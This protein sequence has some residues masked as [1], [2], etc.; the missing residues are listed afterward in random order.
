MKKLIS[1]VMVL[2]MIVCTLISFRALSEGDTGKSC[3][4]GTVLTKETEAFCLETFRDARSPEHL[5]KLVIR[6]ALER[7]TYDEGCATCPQTIDTNR[8][9]F[10]NTFHGVCADFAAFFNTVIQ[11]VSRHK[12][13][14]YVGCHTMLGMDLASGSG[15]AVNYLSVRQADGTVFVYE[16]D[17]TWDLA[18]HKAG[19]SIQ[20][21]RH[22]CVVASAAD[23]PDAIR[24]LFPYN[25]S[26][27]SL[28]YIL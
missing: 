11:T 8:F 3:Y 14:E 10:K 4:T 28:N 23:I 20:G 21:L 22:Y 19:Y 17:T 1:L 12:G 16:I 15:H 5:A 6:F 2:T 9:I 27:F 18:R 26:N 25:Y 24:S 7:F 13:W